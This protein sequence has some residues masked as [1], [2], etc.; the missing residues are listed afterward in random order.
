VIPPL[1]LTHWHWRFATQQCLSI[2]ASHAHLVSPPTFH[3]ISLPIVTITPFEDVPSTRT[4]CLRDQ[5]ESV[6]EKG[7]EAKS[8]VSDEA[9]GYEIVPAIAHEE[10][11]DFV[12]VTRM[13]GSLLSRS[14][15]ETE[16]AEARREHR[17][18]RT[19][20]DSGAHKTKQKKIKNPY[21]DMHA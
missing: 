21:T 6:P 12:K 7:S 11:F 15:G 4:P 3:P 5:K 10:E 18:R 16:L 2:L 20:S 14:T 1:A 13:D 8:E 17:E 9:S 19:C